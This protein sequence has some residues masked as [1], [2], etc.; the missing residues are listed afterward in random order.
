MEQDL[1]GDVSVETKLV[2]LKQKLSSFKNAQYNASV[3][4]KVADLLADKQARDNAIEAMRKAEIAIDFVKN[5]ISEMSKTPGMEDET[6]N[7]T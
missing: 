2:I 7:E 3:D 6:E 1:F 5:L 4:A